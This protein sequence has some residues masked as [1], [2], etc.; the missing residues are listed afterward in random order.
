MWWNHFWDIF[1]MIFV[2]FAFVAYL[3]AMFSVISDLFN[4]RKL[5]GWWKA[6][7]ILCLFV[8][9]VVTLLVYL[10]ARGGGME[11]RAVERAEKNRKAMDYYIRSGQGPTGPADELKKAKELLDTGAITP[12]EFEALKGKVLAD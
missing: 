12:A 9:P 4:D 7:W 6:L 2:A 3:F 10:V 5:S 8:V 11:E 1:W